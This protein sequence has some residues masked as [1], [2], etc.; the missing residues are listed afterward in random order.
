MIRALALLLALLSTPALA[1]DLVADLSQQRVAITA[2]FDGS[3]ILL[4]GAVRHDKPIDQ[5]G[6]IDLVITVSGPLRPVT[7]RKKDRVAGIW[8]NTEAVEVDAAPA[9]Y[10]VVS[11][12]PLFRVISDTED[13][14]HKITVG[15]AIR[16]VGAPQTIQNAST[17][18]D[19]LIRIRSKERL[20]Q[21]DEN[22]VTFL[23]KT[24]F[25]TEIA[26]PANLVEGVYTAKIYL[27]QDR[28]IIAT[29]ETSINVTKVGLERFLYR[30]S[31]DNPLAYGLL[32]L[33]IAIAAG[34]AA[35]AVF[36]YLRS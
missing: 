14:R 9:F 4:F 6:E 28:K 33:F 22:G 32:S 13:L 18:T 29:Y 2:N 16:S 21:L 12:A 23:N 8:V 24:L 19:A 5:V 17:F 7:V 27:T 25:R 20:Y 35:S 34:W 10:K 3:E 15:R 36:R 11:T 31:R 26:L 30:L 1:Q